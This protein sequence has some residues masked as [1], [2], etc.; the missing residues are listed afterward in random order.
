M[1]KL[2]PLSP[3][4]VLALAVGGPAVAADNIQAQRLA[5]CED[6]WLEWKDDAVRMKRF[7]DDIEA[8]YTP[9]AE[10][11]GFAPKAPMQA[12]GFGVVQLYPQSVGMGVGYSLLLNAGFVPARQRLEKQLGK[13][14]SCSTSEGVTAC[15]LPLSDK[16][17]AM[18]M[19]GENGKSKT[20][21]IGCYYFYAQ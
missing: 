19:T 6:S 2:I 12:F 15:S 7:A 21:L 13:P 4:L 3:A 17:T 18:L 5:T 9:G 11:A 14:M 1:R 8:N 16:K 20:S 10:G